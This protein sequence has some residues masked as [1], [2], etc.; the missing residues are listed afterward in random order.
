MDQVRKAVRFGDALEALVGVTRFVELGPDGVLSALVQLPDDVTAP[1]LLRDRDE[2]TTA[3][4]ALATLHVNGVP[5]DWSPVLSGF[6][7]AEVRS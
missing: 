4:T 3:L 6:R 5:F 7:P 1:L 2:V